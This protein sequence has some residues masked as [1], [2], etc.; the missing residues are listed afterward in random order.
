L[1][2]AA[3]VFDLPVSTAI[4]LSFVIIAPVYSLAPGLL[5]AILGA[6]VLIPTTLIL[7]RLIDRTLF[8]ILNA[9]LVFFFSISCV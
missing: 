8:P 7:R 9:L 4:A 6:A 5:R 1:R 3:P 2:R